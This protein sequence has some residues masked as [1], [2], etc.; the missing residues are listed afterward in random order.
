MTV[1]LLAK[2]GQL[3]LQ[4]CLP[5]GGSGDPSSIQTAS[6]PTLGW[7]MGMDIDGDRHRHRLAFNRMI[8][9]TCNVSRAPCVV[10][11]LAAVRAPVLIGISQLD[12]HEVQRRSHLHQACCS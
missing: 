10:L 12:R 8:S 11:R 6:L 2:T 3:V 1:G 5:G 4:S 7:T 9:E